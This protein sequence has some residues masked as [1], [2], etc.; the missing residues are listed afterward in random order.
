AA[1]RRGRPSRISSSA[2]RGLRERADHSWRGMLSGETAGVKR[3]S[4]T[5]V[6]MKPRFATLSLLV[7]GAIGLG[8]WWWVRAPAHVSPLSES[9]GAGDAVSNQAARGADAAKTAATPSGT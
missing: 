1:C 3:A 5:P 8:A 9:P 6:S 2:T 7:C 4:Y